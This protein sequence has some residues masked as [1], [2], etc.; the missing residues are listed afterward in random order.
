VLSAFPIPQPLSQIVAATFL[1]V[2]ISIMVVRTRK[3]RPYILVGWLWYLITLLP[4]I[5]LIQAGGLQSM[6][7]R[8]TYVPLVGIFIGLAWN[9][10]E[11]P[12]RHS[13]TRTVV[14]SSAVALIIACAGG[15]RIQLR[16]WNN[17]ETLL[18]HTLTIAPGGYLAEANLGVELCNQGRWEEGIAHLE[19]VVALAPRFAYAHNHLGRAYFMAGK[20]D[21]ALLH[22]RVA[23]D[24]APRDASAHNNLGI[25]LAKQGNLQEAVAEFQ[26]AVQIQPDYSLARS[27][28][29]ATVRTAQKSHQ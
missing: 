18:R 9:V 16:Y 3:H 22:L 1:L 2:A 4:V 7:D 28:L 10:A 8:F 29:A 23:V 25:A 27:N 24:L 11:I 17:S 15:T 20:T 21:A 6:A 5:G 26:T 19:T 14:S 13:T 12:V